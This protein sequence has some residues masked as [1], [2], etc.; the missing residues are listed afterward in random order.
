ML[1]LWQPKEKNKN[2]DGMKRIRNIMFCFFLIY[3][4]NTVIIMIIIIIIIIIIIMIMY[5]MT[6]AVS[7]CSV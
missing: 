1:G 7:A 6:I 2:D 4:N 5:L 3:I